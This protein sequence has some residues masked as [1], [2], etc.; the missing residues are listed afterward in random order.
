[1]CVSGLAQDSDQWRALVDIVMKPST[2]IKGE[3]N[4][5]QLVKE[6]CAPWN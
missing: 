4:D 1:M 6:G 3:I 2:S 5:S